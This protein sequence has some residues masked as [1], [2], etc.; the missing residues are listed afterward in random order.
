[1][2]WLLWRVG[3][4]VPIWLG[5]PLPAFGLLRLAPGDP[6]S[7]LL[8]R[9]LGR[10][11]TAAE[12]RDFKAEF[13]LDAPWPVQYARWLAGVIQGDFGRSLRTGGSVGSSLVERLPG[14]LTL[15]I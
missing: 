5:I 8:Q 10:P 6:A 1:M 9:D 15:A 11:P 12:L 2:P 13:G 4:L 7:V 3:A 14:T